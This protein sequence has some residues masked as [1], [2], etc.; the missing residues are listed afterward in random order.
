MVGYVLF[1]KGSRALARLPWSLMCNP[2]GMGAGNVKMHSCVVTALRSKMTSS[3]PDKRYQFWIDRGGTFTDVVA[4]LPDGSLVAHKLLSENPTRYED[5][6]LQGI[7]DILQLKPSEPFPFSDIESVKMGTTVATN[8]LL[9]RRGARTVL[10]ITKGFRDLLRIGYQA[11]PRLFDRHIVLPELL[12]ERVIEADERLSAAGEVLKELDFKALATALE[13]ANADGIRSCAIVLLH[14]YKYPVHERRAAEIAREVGF[15]QISVSSEVAPLIRLVSRGDTTVVD[16]YLTPVLKRYVDKI[17]AS[18]GGPGGTRLYFMQSSGGLMRADRF[19]GRDSIF[20]G[21]AGGVIGAVRTS[22][23]AGYQRVISF[24]MGGTSTDVA[25]Y[26]G[27]LERTFETEVA[28]VRMRVPMLSIETVAAGGGSIL[29]FNQGRYRVG[30]D[31]AGADP[32]PACYRRGGPLTVTDCNVMLGRIQPGHFPKIFGPDGDQALDRDVV[33][34]RFAALSAEIREQTGDQRTAEQ[35]AEGFL[36]IAC[37]NMANAIKR[38]SVQRGHDVTEYVLN[39]FGGA[40]GQHACSVADLLGIRTVFIHPLAGVLS[41]YGMGLADTRVVLEQGVEEGLTDAAVNHLAEILKDLEVRGRARLS[42]QDTQGVEVVVLHRIHLRYQGSDT[43]LIIDYGTIAAM[44]ADFAR[45]HRARYG[46]VMPDRNIEVSAVLLEVIGRPPSAISKGSDD[47]AIRSDSLPE[48]ATQMVMASRGRS[49][50]APVFRRDDLVPGHRISG[51]ALITETNAT[52]VVDKDWTANVTARGELVLERVERTSPSAQEYRE[53]SGQ[54]GR[55][56][57]SKPDPVM[58]EVFNNLFMSI[59]EQM[60]AVLAN[61]AHSVNIKE[62]L[63]FSCAIFDARG[64]LVANAPHMPVHLGSMGESVQAV[65]RDHRGTLQPGDVVMLNAPYNGGTHLPDV[66]VVTPVF[67]EGTGSVLFYVASRGHHADIGG[68]TPGSMP[69][70]SMRIE[71]EGVL[72]EDFKLARAFHIGFVDAPGLDGMSG[73]V[74][75]GFRDLPSRGRISLSCLPC[76]TL[77]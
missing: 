29:H 10:V 2:F 62:R 6:C 73:L 77:L 16:A 63:D 53:V 28:G 46:F 68:I 61:T 56:P 37:E 36:R 57:H 45:A 21:P 23:M 3:T 43:A 32:G 49:C 51:P 65:I 31:S 72:F 58:L 1:S 8:A 70:H 20:S 7:R 27:T 12:Y 60:G 39:C 54:T 66:T 50:E 33:A 24:D 76:P 67:D 35:V 30:P 47:E 69:P 26:S 14:G 34:R 74:P 42:A 64:E 71:E 4:R 55:L 59:A 44:R 13:T 18:L 40:G 9:E 5:A 38:V 52:T 22:E 17:A 19:R 11:R 25:L 41:A 75:L 15:E 48:P